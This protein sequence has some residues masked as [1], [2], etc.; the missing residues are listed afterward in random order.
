MVLRTYHILVASVSMA[1]VVIQLHAGKVSHQYFRFT[2][3]KLRNNNAANS[4]QL[5]EFEIFHQDQPLKVVTATNPGGSN[6]SA[7]RPSDAIDGDLG[8]KWLDFEKG[9][10]VLDFGRRVTADGYRWA[11]AND[12]LERD[13]VQWTLEGSDNNATWTLIDSR[14]G[15]DFP[16][17]PGRFEWLP[18]LGFNQIPDGPVIQRFAIDLSGNLSEDGASIQPGETATLVWSVEDSDTLMLYSGDQSVQLD[19]ESGRLEVSPNATT[20]YTLT[21]TNPN[22]E[23]TAKLTVLVGDEVLPPVLNEF[24]ATS[25]GGTESVRDE[26]GEI[27]DWIELYNPNPVPIELVGFHLTDDASNP[28][29]W[30]F[31]DRVLVGAGDYLIVFAS[32][33][34]RANDPA[35]LHTNFKLADA[36]EYL[37]LTDENGIPISEELHPA[38]PEQYENFSFGIVT[39]EGGF[40]FF[41]NPTP[42]GPND[43]AHGLPVLERVEFFPPSRTFAGSLE[44]SLSG[45]AEGD[46]IRYT[47]DGQI[48]TESSTRYNGSPIML[49]RTTQVRAR[50]FRTQRA[51]GPVSSG[52][53]TSIDSSLQS[54]TSDLP[55]IVLDNFDRGSVTSGSDPEPGYF[56]LLEPNEEGITQLVGVPQDAHRMGFKR[57]GASTLNDAKGNYR[58]EF[59]QQDSEEDQ[60]VNLLGLS[61]HPEWILFAPYRFDRSLVR[62]PFIHQLSNNI[63]E[64]APRSVPVEVFLSTSGGRV[65]ENDYQG[66]YVLQ[67]RISRDKDRVDISR[68]GLEDTEEPDVSGGYILSIDRRDPGDSGFRSSLGHPEDPAIAGPQPWFN[69]VYPKESNILPEQR[70]YITGYIDEMESALYSPNFKDPIEGYAKWIDVDSFIGHHL[71]VTFTKDPDALRLS[72]YMNKPRNEKLRMGPIW[73]FDRTMGNDADGRSGNPEG[74]DPPFETAQFFLYDWWGQLFQ[75]PNFYQAW[76]DRWQALRE[77]EMSDSKL[78]ELVDHFAARVEATQER[79]FDRWPE[80]SPNGGEFSNLPGW[81]GEVDHLK[82]WLVRRAAWIDSQFLSKPT[83]SQA[84]GSFTPGT[85]LTILSPDNEVYYTTDDTD[86]RASGGSKYNSAIELN[87]SVIITARAF[88]GTEWSGP[89]RRVF[90]RGATPSKANLVISEL[91]YHPLNPTETE[92]ASGHT[93]AD[94][95]EFIELTNIGSESLDLSGVHFN[96]GLEFEFAPQGLGAPEI[97]PGNSL[98]LVKNLE[99]FEFRYRQSLTGIQ[100]GGVY[101]LNLSNGGELI[102]LLDA[103]GN[104]IQSFT[105]GDASPWADTPDGAGPSLVLSDVWTNPDPSLPENWKPSFTTGGTPGSIETGTGGFTGDPFADTD[106]NGFADLVDYAFGSSSN[107]GQ[108]T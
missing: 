72:T 14:T 33:K 15:S 38:Y 54:F 69:F 29:K 36:G 25:G 17:P 83:F 22:G 61:K 73:D 44:L 65:S 85:M 81:E 48:P 49:T 32:G 8:T 97:A 63:G 91:H 107:P 68:L 6:P 108:L 60:N 84:G 3:T 30:S 99:A 4:V 5:A 47:T 100:I 21:A 18:L 92:I 11:T 96:E 87:Q 62:I 105:Y 64:Y 41:A 89:V 88:N 82:Q 27:S 20:T 103:G 16:T 104:V 2:P 78:T 79:N 7:E 50:L 35:K 59:R 67:E 34:D 10:L 12:A 76:I 1:A 74:W 9:S 24:L 52:A 101:N 53:W 77:S 51:P 75:D 13:P 98:V 80:V 31:P 66:V 93:D 86:P 70:D 43:T 28:K 39:G 56:T 40:D 57:R 95:F 90:V 26:D 46:V 23:I 102:Q 71:L 94:M 42:G 55:L 58:I 106:G 37:A 19:Q 45:G